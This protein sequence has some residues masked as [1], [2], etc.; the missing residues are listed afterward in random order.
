MENL[1]QPK[2]IEWLESAIGAVAPRMALQRHRARVQFGFEAAQSTR[3]RGHANVVAGPESMRNATDRINL[4]KQVRDL[5]QNFGLFRSIISKVALYAVGQL[6]Y[7]ARTGDEKKNRQ[8]EA[9]LRRRFKKK[10]CDISGRYSFRQL[11]AIALQSALRD[12]DMAWLYR[13]TGDGVRIQGIESDRIGGN[14]AMSLTPDYVQGISFDPDTGAVKSYRVYERTVA[15][16]YVN[17]KD[18]AEENISLF[19]D[20]WRVDQYRGIT[21]FA[22]VVNTARDLKE[23]LEATLIG[24]KFE[25]YHGGFITNDAGRLTDNDANY[26]INSTQTG[27]NGTALT[28]EKMQFGVLRYLPT[29]SKID[30]VKSERPS[31]QWQS[32]TAMLVRDIALAL[33]LPFGFVYDLA[34]LGG[35]SAR[36]DAQQAHR[37]IQGWQQMLV[38]CGL[39]AAKDRMLMDGLASGDVEG[40]DEVFNGVWQFPPAI[41]IDAGRE[42]AAGIAE[43]RAGMR[44]KADWYAEE[45]KDAEEQQAI[46]VSEAR[47]T[48][49][50]AKTLSQET[51]VPVNIALDLIESKNPN[52]TQQFAVVNPEETEAGD[53]ALIQSIGIGGTQSLAD[54]IGKVGTREI[55]PETAK[56]ILIS[57][58]GMSEAQAATIFPAGMVLPAQP[59][60][61]APAIPSAQPEKEDEEEDEEEVEIKMNR[62]VSASLTELA[63]DPREARGEDGISWLRGMVRRGAAIVSLSEKMKKRKEL[64]ADPLKYLSARIDNVKNF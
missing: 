56:A 28:E 9:Y 42:S 26:V 48:I 29:G 24:V 14:V 30:L 33:N 40:G 13:K 44:T 25:N 41:T 53:G 4:I 39:D 49:E 47:S 45:G 23:V 1:K 62:R 59:S 16:A 43:V 51:G 18:I 63:N 54:I 21:P 37:V 36:M 3:L 31:G 46:I 34:G 50:S 7:Q 52:P 32:Y 2:K 22:P 55:S 35:P 19:M 15:D 10:S 17:P 20:P 27:A 6:R 38:E 58:F 5:E 11:A 61:S 64:S 8:I 60:V 57:V 12:G